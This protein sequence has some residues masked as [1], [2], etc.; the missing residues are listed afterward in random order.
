MWPVLFRRDISLQSDAWMGA[1]CCST[2]LKKWRWPHIP[3]SNKH[4]QPFSLPSLEHREIFAL[5]SEQKKR[6]WDFLAWSRLQR[7]KE[8]GHLRCGVCNEN[9][10]DELGDVLQITLPFLAE[11]ERPSGQIDV[12]H[13]DP[14]PA[15]TLCNCGCESFPASS[16]PLA[17]TYLCSGHSRKGFT[18]LMRQVRYF[19]R[20]EE[21]A[22]AVL[23]PVVIYVP[24]ERL[25]RVFANGA[26]LWP[27]SRL[28]DDDFST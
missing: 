2:K 12:G 19:V 26:I 1:F 4:S 25:A 27:V 13:F 23:L 11:W 14:R 17:V 18:R 24:V 28:G 6:T 20:F 5:T 3:R 7:L 16:G 21:N 10:V 15:E 9:L 22:H 8:A